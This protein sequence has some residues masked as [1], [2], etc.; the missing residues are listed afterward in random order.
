[1]GNRSKG[2]MKVVVPRGPT[3]DPF[4]FVCEWISM[5]K[6]GHQYVV[7]PANTGRRCCFKGVELSVGPHWGGVL[8]T[9]SIIA[10]ATLFFTH[11]IIVGLPVWYLA[12]TVVSSAVTV[13]FLLATACT[14]PGIVRQSADRRP[15]LRFCKEC[16]IWKPEG[17]DHCDEC[18]VCIQDLDH[19][20]PWMGKCVG[21]GNML[22]FKLFNATW[23]CLL[24]FVIAAAVLHEGKQDTL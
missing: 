2:E 1:M 8:Y 24:L 7:C 6:Y 22:W 23:I 10:F 17:A 21:R 12:V 16:S 11:H 4:G 15:G 9:I 14:D 19:H 18:G 20:C 3:T 5:P 13:A